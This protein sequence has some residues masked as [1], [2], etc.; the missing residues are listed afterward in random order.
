MKFVVEN[1]ELNPI[2]P[3]CLRTASSTCVRRLAHAVLPA[4]L[5]DLRTK[6][7]FSQDADDLR[8]TESGFL[9][10]ETPGREI[11]YFRVVQ[12]FEGTSIALNYFHPPPKAI[13]SSF[14]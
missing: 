4:G 9:H 2:S 6:F 14:L 7:D 8:F 12:V 3:S 13:N 5:V 1:S 10:V 11:L